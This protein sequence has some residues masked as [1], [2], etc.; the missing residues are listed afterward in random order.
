MNSHRRMKQIG[1]VASL[2]VVLVIFFSLIVPF[3]VRLFAEKTPV[4]TPS[5]YQ[6]IKLEQEAIIVHQRPDGSRTADIVAQV[7]NPNSRA[8]LSSY[9]VTFKVLNPAGEE[10]LSHTEKTHLLPGALQYVVAIDV[11]IPVE[12]A[13]GRLQVLLPAEGDLT[14]QPLPNGLNPPEF[15][16]LLQG[17]SQRDIAGIPIET[18]TGLVTNASTFDWE[19]VEVV[20]VGLN[21]QRQIIAVGKTFLGRLLVGEQRQFTVTWPTTGE[22]IRN[23]IALPSTDM[24]NEENLVETLGNS[25]TLR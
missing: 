13:I 6:P 25:G 5:P 17:R 19:K 24:F 12:A 22:P 3:S 14:F 11:P 23:V 7:R 8:G 15:Q 4:V 20:A 21:A 9:V 1:Y 16:T 2:V 10:I 18:Q